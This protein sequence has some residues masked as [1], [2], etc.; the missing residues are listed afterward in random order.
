MHEKTT[1]WLY[2]RNL[3]LLTALV[4]GGVLFY[5]MLVQV[6]NMAA[7][8]ASMS[9]SMASMAADMGAMRASMQQLDRTVGRGARDMQQMNPMQMLLPE[10]R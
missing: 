10:G 8:M 5:R 4:A 1:F 3:V 7:L 9:G 6:E 2:A